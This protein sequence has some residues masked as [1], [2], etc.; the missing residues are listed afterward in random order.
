[1]FLR[2]I[3]DAFLVRTDPASSIVKPAHIHITSAPQTRNANVFSTNEVSV[4]GVALASMVIATAQM[5]AKRAALVQ[6]REPLRL[7]C[8]MVP[9]SFFPRARAVGRARTPP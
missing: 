3:T 2:Q 7:V 8:V 4:L 9:P 5:P 6:R 1:M